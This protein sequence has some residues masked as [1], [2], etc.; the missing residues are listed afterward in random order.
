ML[1]FFFSLSL[2]LTTTTYIGKKLKGEE[3][4]YGHEAGGL[5][6]WGMGCITFYECFH[7]WIP[8]SKPVLQLVLKKCF[9][10]SFA[11][12]ICYMRYCCGPH[13]F[14]G[15]VGYMTYF[16]S[17]KFKYWWIHKCKT[18]VAL[19]PSSFSVNIR[20]PLLSTITAWVEEQKILTRFLF[21]HG[22]KPT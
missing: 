18:K 3:L 6:C 8:S 22:H 13:T 14:R 15:L 7:T 21:E 1:V 17:T 11:P 19:F 9:F 10:F 16:N 12:S 20:G 5:L 4:Y 2:L